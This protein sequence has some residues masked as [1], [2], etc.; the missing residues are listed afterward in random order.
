MKFARWIFAFLTLTA[1]LVWAQR[2]RGV[3]PSRELPTW[4]YRHLEPQEVSPGAYQQV[5]W[6]LV[7]SLGAQGWELVSVSPWV[8]RN[9]IHQPRKEGE[10]KLVTQNY[11]AFY[12]K[13]QRPE[14]R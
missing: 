8:M 14:Q 11:M 10:P 2:E 9:D 1:V 13:R 6:S 4:E 12:F 7:T 5:D 3:A